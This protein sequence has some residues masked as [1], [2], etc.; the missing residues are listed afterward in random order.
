MFLGDFPTII[1]ILDT[2]GTAQSVFP[3]RKGDADVCSISVKFN[4]QKITDFADSRLSRL[5]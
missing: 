2:P 4:L 5:R 1:G 3:V